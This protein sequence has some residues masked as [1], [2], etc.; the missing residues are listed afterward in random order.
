M[1]RCKFGRGKFQC[2]T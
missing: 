1:I 2:L